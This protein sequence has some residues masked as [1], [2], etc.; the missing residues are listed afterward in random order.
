MERLGR[1]TPTFTNVEYKKTKGKEAI[2][3]YKSTGQALTKWQEIQINAI[4]AVEDGLWKHMKYG[5]CVSRRNGKGE[6]LAAR[7]FDGIVN[8]GEKVCHT[9]HR[10]TT[11]HD[12]FNRLYTL[13]KKAGSLNPDSSI[14]SATRQPP[15]A[16]RRCASA[17]LRCSIH[18]SG[19][20][21][22]IFLK[23]RLNEDRL[24]PE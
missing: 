22:L 15:A 5:L 24:R 13:L 12:A 9:A 6:I 2:K 21:S 4:M 18:F 10:T 16:S 1:E 23:S 17:S 20:S 7:E 14:A 11:S 3:L 19:V 8:L